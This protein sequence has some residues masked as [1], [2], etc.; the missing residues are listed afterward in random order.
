MSGVTAAL[1]M[2]FPMTG[3]KDNFHANPLYLDT[4]TEACVL[5]YAV[6]W[7][8][9][10]DLDSVELSIFISFLQFSDTGRAGFLTFF[11]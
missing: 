11:Y 9:E 8:I 6:A 2:T 10:Y 7:V 4:N 5:L 1:Y 3:H